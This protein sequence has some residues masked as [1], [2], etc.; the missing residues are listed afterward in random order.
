[1]LSRMRSSS[2]WNRG[3]LRQSKRGEKKISLI[4]YLLEEK[5]NI[6]FKCT[7]IYYMYVCSSPSW[8]G[9]GKDNAWCLCGGRQGNL[10]WVRSH[11]VLPWLPSFRVEN[12][13]LFPSD[14][15]AIVS[16]SSTIPYLYIS[17]EFS[18]YLPLPCWETPWFMT[19]MVSQH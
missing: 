11:P 15:K 5:P 8:Q 7:H 9:L 16:S 12:G 17:A 2:M 18:S 3:T 6:K 19:V 10:G 14:E 1:M 13:E 4:L